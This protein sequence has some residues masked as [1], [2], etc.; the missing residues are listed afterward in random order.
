[1]KIA[2]FPQTA[3]DGRRVPFVDEEKEF[4]R[5]M[6]YWNWSNALTEPPIDD[7]RLLNKTQDGRKWA[8]LE[9]PSQ[10]DHE[11]YWMQHS[12]G[13]NWEHY[14]GMGDIYGLRD[15]DNIPLVTILVAQ[16]TVVHARRAS[17]APLTLE[18]KRDLVHLAEI[19]GW[20]ILPD[21]QL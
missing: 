2:G 8:V 15:H 18:D 1:M 6:A 12:V 11:A 3:W 14:S 17:N 10:A 21:E 19:Q 7:T 9:T 5:V 16:D 4:N 13:Y 20:N